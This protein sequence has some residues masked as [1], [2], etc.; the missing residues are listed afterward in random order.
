MQCADCSVDLRD[1]EAVVCDVCGKTLCQPCFT[2]WHDGNTL[3]MELVEAL[4][5]STR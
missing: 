1:D 2:V 5:D 4:K 3:P